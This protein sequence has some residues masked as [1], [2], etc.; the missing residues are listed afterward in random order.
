M[1]VR[2][3]LFLFMVTIGACKSQRGH[4]RNLDVIEQQHNGVRIKAKFVNGQ[5][6]KDQP[7]EI[8]E[9]SAPADENSDNDFLYFDLQ[10]ER[11]G[12]EP[13][14]KTREYLDFQIQDDFQML[15]ETD[16]LRPS[17]VHRMANGRKGVYEYLVVFNRKNVIQNTSNT[18]SILYNDQIF[19]LGKQLFAFKVR[20][21]VNQ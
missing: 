16:T 17:F 21:I 12:F 1:M 19:G 18:V 14:L 9:G 13:D 2:S 4:D 10:L 6:F 7:S 15:K 20:D 11:S 5:H 3:F 8:G